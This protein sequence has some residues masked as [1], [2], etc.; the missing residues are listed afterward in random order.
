MKNIEKQYIL[1]YTKTVN[2]MGKE[3]IYLADAINQ[4]DKLSEKQSEYMKLIAEMRYQILLE[5]YLKVLLHYY[6]KKQTILKKKLQNLLVLS[7]QSII[8]MKDI[9]GLEKI[10]A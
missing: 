10:F 1:W 3:G 4:A 2:T 7:I 6:L 8:L 9:L 5:L